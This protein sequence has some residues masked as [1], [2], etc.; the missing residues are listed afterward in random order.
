VF[1]YAH[2]DGDLETLSATYAAPLQ[3]LRT[4][5]RA[6]SAI[7]PDESVA[8]VLRLADAPATSV[9]SKRRTGDTSTLLA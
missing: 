2:D 6:L 4:R 8:L 1:L 5:F 9:R 7:E 3:G